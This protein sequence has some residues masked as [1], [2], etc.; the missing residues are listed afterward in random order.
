MSHHAT[1][2]KNRVAWIDL[3]SSDAAGSREFYS[4]LFGWDLEV[5]QDPQYGGYAMARLEGEDVAGIGPAQDPN[6]PTA[7][8][9]YFG[10]DDL[11]ALSAKVTDAGGTVV[12]A[13]FDVGDQGRMAVFQDPTG[14]FFSAWQ[15]QRM[16]TFRYDH[17]NTY[18]W[19]EV[20]ARGVDAV[21]DFYTRVFG[22]ENHLQPM[23]EGQPP[24]NE[25]HSEGHAVAGAWEMSADVPAEVPSY[26]QVYFNVDDVDDTHRRA[27]E[28][29]ASDMVPP[30]DFPGGRF[31]ILVD[32]QGASFAIVKTAQS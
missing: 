6:A 18:G 27:L 11:E 29:G 14:A 26:W 19:A 32:P 22:W 16:G 13:P 17:A 23:G 3:N 4:S 30:T 31:A 9:L 24:Y 2:T 5:T 25:L 12:M 15:G 7:W 20:N 1:D 21:V 28:L 10:S 8:S